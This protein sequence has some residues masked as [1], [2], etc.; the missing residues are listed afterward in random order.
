MADLLFGRKATLQTVWLRFIDKDM[1]KL[2]H[3]EYDDY[4]C[5]C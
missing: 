2:L 4:F 3:D 1:S 5:L